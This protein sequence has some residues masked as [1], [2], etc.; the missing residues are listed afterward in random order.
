[1]VRHASRFVRCICFMLALL[2]TCALCPVSITAQA[3]E[4][5]YIAPTLPSDAEPY[6]PEK[7]EDLDEEVHGVFHQDQ[8]RAIQYSLSPAE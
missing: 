5:R 1:M 7:P 4:A 2:L 8:I 6:D 3:E